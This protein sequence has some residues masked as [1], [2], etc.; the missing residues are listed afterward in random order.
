M[1]VRVSIKVKVLYFGQARDAAGVTDEEFSLSGVASL[2]N[3]IE[4]T[5]SRHAALANL[6]RATR[7]AVNAELAEDDQRLGDGDEVAFLPPVAGG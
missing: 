6:N 7:M 3:L 1:K 2:R 4:M 5:E